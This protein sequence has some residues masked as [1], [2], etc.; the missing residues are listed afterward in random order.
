MRVFS[1]L[2]L[3]LLLG[4]SVASSAV[5]KVAIIQTTAPLQDHAQPSIEAAFKEAMQTAMR[6]ALAMGCSWVTLS[7]ALV[8]ENM[9]TVQILATDTKP[10]EEGGEEEPGGESGLWSG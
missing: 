3:A 7:K 5:A 4:L 1:C 9:V 6:G 10:D 8:L 2:A